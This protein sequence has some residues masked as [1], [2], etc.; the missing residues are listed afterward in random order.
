[1]AKVSLRVA[2]FLP[3]GPQARPTGAA[4]YARYVRDRLLETQQVDLVDG[5]AP[6]DAI[7][8][9][10]G[11][12]RAG[13][14]QPTVTV[15][16]QAGHLLSRRAYTPRAWLIQNWRVASAARRSTSVLVPSLAMSWALTAR[17]HVPEQR[18]V[19][20]DP[21]PAPAFRRSAR[22][23]LDRV[24]QRIRLPERY[25]LYVGS[26]ARRKNLDFLARVWLQVSAQLGPDVQLVLA[27]PQRGGLDGA[28]HVLDAG[29]VVGDELPALLT[30]AIAYLNPSLYE[31]QGVG[32]MEAMA[33]GTPALV[34]A[35][36]A[37]PRTV[38][39]GGL[40]LDAHEPSQW[41]DAM[42]AVAGRQEVRRELSANALKLTAERRAHPPDIG[43]LLRALEG[44]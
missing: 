19:R 15:V 17:L 7:L 41:C 28:G 9:L 44:R 31:G 18:V 24:R 32:A 29:W 4:V 30:G 33:C 21:L 8:S 37:L 26:R 12:F 42:L 22:A 2:C 39:Q 5:R 14:G 16:V 10:D 6:N 13:R 40:V 11:R 3:P 43:P 1:M 25:F 27:G 23:D 35:S 36:G 38:D 20:L 34:A